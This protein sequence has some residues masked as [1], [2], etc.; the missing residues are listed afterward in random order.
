MDREIPKKT[1]QR[2]RRKRWLGYGMAGLLLIG[3]ITW[4]PSLMQSRVN[5]KDLLFSV[6]DR[7]TLE[8]SVSA[9]GKIVPAVE[10][11]I[12]SPVSARIVEVYRRS[13]DSVEAGTPLLKLDLQSTE[14]EYHKQLDEERMKQL[15]LDQLR[16]N[17]ETYLGDLAMKVKVQAMKVGRMEADLRN[18]RYLDSLGSGTTDRVRQAEL[19]YNTGC[20]ELE[21]L[22][23]QYANEQKVKEADLKVK[24][25]EL[26]IFRKSLS[27]TRRTLED[28]QLRSPRKAILTSIN[29]QVGSQVAPGSQVAVVSD[30]S[31]FRVDG[32][33]A[34][35]Y[36]DRIAAGARA[37]VLVGHERLEGMVSSVTPL[38][39]DGIMSFTVQL[40]DSSNRRLRS[41]LKVD[42]YVINA[43]REE[44]LRISNG[45]FYVGAGEYE[46]FVKEGSGRL[47]KRKVRLGACSYDQVEV[48]DGLKEGDCVV[49]SDM[50]MYQSR[51]QIKLKEKE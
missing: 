9:S 40:D 42:I 18:E 24:Q 23:Q 36:S 41:G 22:R 32:E 6:V 14:T 51:T 25:L 12:T 2:E 29:T 33:A 10:E 35:S 43:V 4:I 3:A 19:A 15:Q 48:L 38:S 34:E 47:V 11:I 1:L 37:M 31:H 28:A 16:M 20:L 13:G 39:R 27:E 30:L 44:A 5:E 21:Q 50:S 46:L 26:D 8:V 7:G 49:V 17:N 45:S